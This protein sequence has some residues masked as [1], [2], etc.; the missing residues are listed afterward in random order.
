MSPPH[1]IYHLGFQESAL[2]RQ[3]KEGL[4]SRWTNHVLDR[5]ERSPSLCAFGV[6]ESHAS[7]DAWLSA[8]P[9]AQRGGAK[10]RVSS[11]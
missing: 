10:A 11:V 1:F 9:K 8:T 3:K 5:T 7:R 6:A 2:L 4:N